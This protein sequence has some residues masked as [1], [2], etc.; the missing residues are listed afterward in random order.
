MYI[1]IRCH[2][3]ITDMEWAVMIIITFYSFP[4]ENNYKQL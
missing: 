1:I 4:A 3:N 2:D